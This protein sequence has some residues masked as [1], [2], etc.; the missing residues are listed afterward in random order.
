MEV[1]VTQRRVPALGEQGGPPGDVRLD[2]GSQRGVA[3]QVRELA[4]LPGEL[5]GHIGGVRG[6]GVQDRRG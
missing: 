3:A 4:Q 5:A 1:V 6:P 2:G